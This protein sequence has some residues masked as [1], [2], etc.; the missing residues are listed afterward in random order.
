MKKLKALFVVLL[1]IIYAFLVYY[2]SFIELRFGFFESHINNLRLII[3]L[4]AITILY[5]YIKSIIEETRRYTK[6]VKFYLTSILRILYYI[7]VLSALFVYL[8]GSIE[9]LSTI[10]G[11]IG[12]GLAISLQKPILN[13]VGFLSILINRIYSKGDSI[14]IDDT[15]GV[16]YDINVMNTRIIEYDKNGLNMDRMVTFPNSIV[17][18]KKVK[19]FSKPNDITSFSFTVSITY[20]SDLD[21]AIKKIRKIVNSSWKNFYMKNKEIIEKQGYSKLMEKPNYFVSSIFNSSSID[22]TIT[23]KSPLVLSAKLRT[24]LVNSIFKNL[25]EKK[26]EFAYPHMEVL[27]RK[28]QRKN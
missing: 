22:L 13:F 16:I 28:K 11:L 23:F 24:S 26:I 10:I 9:G 14:E 15:R 25:P 5:S 20:D 3:L 2:P 4:S 18:D 27:F 12:A 8:G 21:K 7:L 19:N 6:G 1:F 17:L